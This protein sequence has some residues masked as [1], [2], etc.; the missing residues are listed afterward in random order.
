MPPPPSFVSPRPAA[1]PMASS[2][3]T[4]RAKTPAATFSPSNAQ[5]LSLL[6]MQLQMREKIYALETVEERME[7]EFREFQEWKRYK[8]LKNKSGSTPNIIRGQGCV[9]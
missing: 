7:R 9:G 3:G 6:Q 5:L 1:S 8:E 2:S 4:P